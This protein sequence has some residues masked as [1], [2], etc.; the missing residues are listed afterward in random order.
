MDDRLHGRRKI[1]L[2]S[3]LCEGNKIEIGFDDF[4]V[5]YVELRYELNFGPCKHFS[6]SGKPISAIGGQLLYRYM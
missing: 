1:F 4:K 6:T 3:E 2:R 5:E